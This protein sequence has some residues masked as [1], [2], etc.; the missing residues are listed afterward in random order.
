MVITGCNW[1]QNDQKTSEYLSYESWKD[2]LKIKDS[3][4]K[5]IYCIVTF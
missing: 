1:Y 5:N 4:I 2:P 3:S